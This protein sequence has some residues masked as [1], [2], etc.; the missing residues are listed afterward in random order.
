MPSSLR[1]RLLL[2]VAVG[3]VL[4]IGMPW[5]VAGEIPVL[6]RIA[7][8]VTTL[9][10]VLLAATTRDAVAPSYRWLVTAGLTASLAADALLA[11]PGEYVSHALGALGIAHAAYLAAFATRAP[12]FRH[13]VPVVACVVMG[14]AILVPI[15]PAVGGVVRAGIIAYVLMLGLMAAQGA[16]WLLEEAAATSARFAALGAALL[17]SSDTLLLLD[18]FV[19]PVPARDL[20]I[21]APYWLAQSCLALSVQRPPPPALRI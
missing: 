17:L 3:A 2:G 21:L 14:T 10:L 5:L 4:T 11:F 15:L 18:R 9:L 16:N 6:A 7:R 1:R 20:L 13:R 12:L 8:P 19:S